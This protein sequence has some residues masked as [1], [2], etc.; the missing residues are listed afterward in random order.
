MNMPSTAG[1][2]LNLNPLESKP[3]SESLESLGLFH[4]GEQLE[5]T[6]LDYMSMDDLLELGQYPMEPVLVF[7]LMNLFAVMNEGSV[8]LLLNAESFL[9][10]FPSE[11]KT[12]AADLLKQ[13]LSTYK[14]QGYDRLISREPN[15]FVPL[16][17]VEEQIPR[18]YFQKYFVCESDLK[19]RLATFLH[20]K[21]AE[22]PSSTTAI[23]IIEEL[24][25]SEFTIR[26]GPKRRPIVRDPIQENALKLGLCSQL[27]IISGGPGTGKTAL[28]VN[29]LRGLLRL[30]IEANEILLGAPTGRAA[31]RMTESIRTQMAGIAAP[32]EKDLSLLQLK[33]ATIHRI[34]KYDPRRH[35]FQYHAKRLL[36]SR[37]IVVDEVSMVDLAMM[38]HLLKAI[39]PQ[40]TR[41]VF[42]GDKNQLPSVEAG[43]VLADLIPQTDYPNQFKDNLI[44]LKTVFRSGQR[45]IELAHD[46]NS[47]IVPHIT[48]KEFDFA[49]KMKDDGWAFVS[50][51][52]TTPLPSVLF[53]WA[54][55]HYFKNG[56][57]GKDSFMALVNR[58]TKYSHL[59]LEQT[60]VGRSLLANIF[61]CAEKSRILT[62]TRV[63]A[64][65]CEAVN[66]LM[67]RIFTRAMRK[68][69]QHHSV[70]FNGALII[71]RRNDYAKELFN[72][73]IGIVL[74]DVQGIVKI[75]F[76]RTD[77]FY[78]YSADVLPPFELAFALTVHQSQG[79]EYKEILLILP[80]DIK[81]RLLTREMLYTAVTRAQK[82]AIIYGDKKILKK[83]VQRRIQRQTGMVD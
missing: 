40:K 36:P 13:F 81:H 27:A 69:F 54:Q 10:K 56:V 80:D 42:L 35:R 61:T 23:K 8:C 16:I 66:L 83:A 28:M 2:K 43:A 11:L 21:G 1:K 14:R 29:L 65:G 49:L 47:G 34:L 9:N 31:Q 39:D 19:Q 32:T 73:D 15:A 75:Y 33:G 55:Q 17:L 53:Q 5:L 50:D 41:L 67:K 3:I 82:K 79:S 12:K 74:M 7:T 52:E 30:G 38:D 72:G 45:L 71:V 51:I 4:V 44:M 68:R 70:L 26:I 20:N 37:V 57:D 78:S 62:L 48:T 76:Q 64:F 25:S 46:I 22:L 60:Q 18:L 6:H 77:I 58:A 59:D 24:Y 63:G